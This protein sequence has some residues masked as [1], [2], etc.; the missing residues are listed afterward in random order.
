MVVC[1]LLPV[2]LVVSNTNNENETRVPSSFPLQVNI[3]LEQAFVTILS[4]IKFNELPYV[5]NKSY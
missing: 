2:S 5:T 1:I 3:V 4:S